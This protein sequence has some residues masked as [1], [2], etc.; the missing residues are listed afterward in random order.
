VLRALRQ[1]TRIDA[2]K[3]ARDHA[4]WMGETLRAASGSDFLCLG[5]FAD[6]RSIHDAQLALCDELVEGL[7]AGDWLDVGSGL[8][9]PAH[10]W[11]S[12]PKR[13]ITAFE[14]V[15][16]RRDRTPPH[17][18]LTVR[19]GD[20][21]RMPFDGDFDAV[22]ALE[23]AHYARDLGQFVRQCWRAL[24]PGGQLRAAVV[25]RQT[26]QLRLYDQ[27][28]LR[29][30]EQGMGCPPLQ[31]LGAWEHHLEA[32]FEDVH[33]DNRTADVIGGLAAW[34][35]AFSGV[36]GLPG[37]LGAR[38]MRYLARRGVSGPLRYALVRATRPG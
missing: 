32:G 26:E 5:L 33:V 31:T 10:Y 12:E 18:R 37:G 2:T 6:G 25:L 9:G 38:G 22:I 17:E 27:G 35:D 23:S 16:G 29:A 11:L 30:A 36:D 7:P 1:L 19:G 13:R 3:R 14:I 15:D 28:V 8:G 34:G 21:D 24:R 4:A 20:L